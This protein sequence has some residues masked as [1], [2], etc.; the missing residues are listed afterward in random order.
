MKRAERSTVVTFWYAAGTTGQFAIGQVALAGFGDAW[1]RS[2]PFQISALASDRF[3]SRDAS[4]YADANLNVTLNWERSS[5]VITDSAASS[6]PWIYN[7]QANSNGGLTPA[8]QSEI[9]NVPALN[10]AGAHGWLVWDGPS[11]TP[12]ESA[13]VFAGEHVAGKLVMTSLPHRF[14]ATQ[15]HCHTEPL[16]HEPSVSIVGPERF[17]VSRTIGRDCDHRDLDRHV[18]TGCQ[19][20]AGSCPPCTMHE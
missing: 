9:H 18:V 16:H 7:V 12:M 20:R 1:T 6:L 5:S 2:D 4:Q 19:C 8:L 17:Y 14:T 3:V 15:V 11:R 10:P 13:A